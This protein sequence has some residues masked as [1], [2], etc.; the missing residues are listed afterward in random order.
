[1]LVVGFIVVA[2]TLM[3]ALMV[4]V[5]VQAQRE[6][7]SKFEPVTGAKSLLRRD[8][9]ASGRLNQERMPKRPVL[10]EHL[11]SLELAQRA[12]TEPNR[13]GAYVFGRDLNRRDFDRLKSGQ[14]SNLS[15][16]HKAGGLRSQFVASQYEQFDWQPI[17]FWQVLDIA[18]QAAVK[19]SCERDANGKVRQL[20]ASAWRGFHAVTYV[21]HRSRRIVVAIAGTDFL[22]VDDWKNDAKALIGVAAPYFEAACAYMQHIIEAHS[23]ELKNYRFECAGHSLG[24]GACSV[25]ANRLGRRGVTLNP[26]GT[27]SISRGRVVGKIKVTGAR[28]DSGVFNYVDPDDPAHAVYKAASRETSGAVYWIKPPPKDKAPS[29]WE[30][31]KELVKPRKNIFERAWASYQAHSANVSLDRLVAYEHLSR[32]K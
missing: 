27:S 8:L 13:P 28:A 29:T 16:Q 30:R 25:A 1:M 32:I 19:G 15:G 24:G 5:P 11:Q 6:A 12:Y 10:I 17:Y 21:N 14:S 26:I 23:G 22:S 31:V 18:D 9:L 2:V 3:L 7:G 20:D 4:S